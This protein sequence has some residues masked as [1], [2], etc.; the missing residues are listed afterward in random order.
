MDSD[1]KS[2]LQ[3]NAAQDVTAQLQVPEFADFP[4]RGWGIGHCGDIYFVTGVVSAQDDG[5]EKRDMAFRAEYESFGETYTLV[6][7]ELGGKIAVGSGSV[8]EIPETVPLPSEG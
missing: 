3:S 7:L 4:M 8:L 5:A 2:V 1:S 6:Y